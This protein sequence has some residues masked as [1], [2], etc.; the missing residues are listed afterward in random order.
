MR[1]FYGDGSGGNG[2]SVTVWCDECNPLSVALK[3]A[4]EPVN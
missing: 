2:R 1:E 3:C 4:M